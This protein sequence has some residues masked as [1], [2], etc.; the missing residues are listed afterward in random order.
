MNVSKITIFF[1]IIFLLS[2]NEAKVESNNIKTDSTQTETSAAVDTSI[3]LNK[4][5]K[6]KVESKMLLFIRNMETELNKQEQFN[7]LEQYKNLSLVLK[8]NLDSLTSNC[9]MEGEAHDELHKWLLPY[10]DLT[11]SL[12]NASD[13]NISEQLRLT[14]KDTYKTFNYYFE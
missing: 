13:L 4:G 8:S 3:H 2:C 6:W 14:I 9:V 11:D 5:K 7:S 1:S 10:I 12:N